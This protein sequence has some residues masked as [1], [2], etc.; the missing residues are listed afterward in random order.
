M[1]PFP[2]MA[3]HATAASPPPG[4]DVNNQT[5]NLVDAD[6]V[7][8]WPTSTDDINTVKNLAVQ[9]A[10]IFATQLGASAMLLCVLLVM[11]ASSKRRSSAFIFNVLALVCNVIRCTIQCVE[12]VGPFMDFVLVVMQ[13]YDVAGIHEAVAQSV[14]CSVMTTLV[15]IFLQAALIFQVKVVVMTAGRIQRVAILSFCCVIS[16]LAIAFRLNL[17]VI[18][19]KNTINSRALSPEAVDA[20][21]WAQSVSN[22]C[23][24][25][26]ICTFSLIFVAK[27]G[28][29]IRARRHMGLKQFGAMQIIFIMGCQTLF[30]PVIFAI[31]DYYA[32]RGAQLGSFVETLV[33][34]FLPLSSMWASTDVKSRRVAMPANN[35]AHRAIPVGHSAYTTDD[36][37]S[38]KRK[39]V[40]DDTV[41]TL[42]A[43][44]QTPTSSHH[45]SPVK[46]EARGEPKVSVTAGHR[47]SYMSDTD[48]LEMQKIGQ[49]V[50]VDRS[51]T[52]R[53]DPHAGVGRAR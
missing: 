16:L 53:S 43:S 40:D 47:E 51:Y 52:V 19:C 15:F 45:N 32:M 3:L 17:L 39:L 35:P 1:A 21:N 11:T 31:L 10:I 38:S 25:V 5:F 27:L 26:A 24:I 2:N 8:L 20:Q 49:N 29:A 6:G 9:T 12:M 14:T 33:A 50:R 41:D 18:N 34:I 23:Q 46:L 30:V 42:V 28:F 13:I 22:I 4:F 7:T 37:Y 44:S 36:G 48:D